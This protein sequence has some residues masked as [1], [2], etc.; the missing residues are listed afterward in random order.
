MESWTS[1]T[2]LT[3]IDIPNNEF[4]QYDT[5][6]IALSTLSLVAGRVVQFELTRVG[7]DGGD[8]LSGDWTLLA[9][10]VKFS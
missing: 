6:E 5:Q 3:A 9:W 2:N 4:W 8:D 1:G 10:Q 7:T